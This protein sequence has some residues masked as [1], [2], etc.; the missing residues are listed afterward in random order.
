MPAVL[1]LNALICASVAGVT[2]ARPLDGAVAHSSLESAG[3]EIYRDVVLAMPGAT[4]S[5]PRSR[6]APS[7]GWVFR[8]NGVDA[9]TGQ[10]ARDAVVM[11][12]FVA[13]NIPP[14]KYGPHPG[15]GTPI[16]EFQAAAWQVPPGAPLGG[17]RYAIVAVGG[18]RSAQFQQ[19]NVESSLLTVVPGP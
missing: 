12:W 8:V 16:D 17:I 7:E 2:L 11:T 4:H 9:P 15:S 5:T 10:V 14:I 3:L 19:F 18:P 13:G 6:A 1:S